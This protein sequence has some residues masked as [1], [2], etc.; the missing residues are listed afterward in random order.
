MQIPY[1]KCN[2]NGNSFIILINNNSSPDSISKSKIKKICNMFIPLVDGCIL[3]NYNN[4]EIK[5][6]YYNNDGSWETFCLNGLRCVSLIMGRINHGLGINPNNIE[7]I[8]NEIV[9]KTS[10]DISN[11]NYVFVELNKPEYKLKNI[12]INNIVGDYIDSGAKHFVCNY[13][14]DWDDINFIKEEMMNIRNNSIFHPSGINVN[15]YKIID[16]NTLAVKTYEKGIE[17][18]MDSCASGSYACAYDYSSK[19]DIYG[20]I[21]VLN[22]GGISQIIFNDSYTNNLFK[23]HAEIENEG[24]LEI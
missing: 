15:Y 9:Y 5:A 4:Q 8:M 16:K 17:K 2:G 11:L 18:I 24:S 10:I 3:V 20:K 23:G 12:A 21:K 7:I 22:D 13:V 1:Y 19:N 14:N 6:N